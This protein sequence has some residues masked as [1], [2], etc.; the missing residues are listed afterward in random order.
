MGLVASF[1]AFGTKQA[2]SPSIY[3]KTLILVPVNLV[4]PYTFLLKGFVQVYS[5]QDISLVIAWGFMYNSLIDIFILTDEVVRSQQL[6]TALLAPGHI[7]SWLL[8]LHLSVYVAYL[9]AVA[10]SVL[11]TGP[12]LGLTFPHQLVPLVTIGPLVTVELLAWIIL[13][14]RLTN[15]RSFNLV[16]F[17]L[18]LLQVMSCV[19]YPLTALPWLLRPLSATLAPARLSILVRAI[20]PR[21]AA[22]WLAAT[23][24]LALVAFLLSRR[25]LNSYRMHGA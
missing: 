2:R 5:A 7:T 22:L 24:V 8:G 10:V 19:L 13:A 17:T 11:L 25:L 4:F 14:V 18:D 9:P 12:V 21:N 20:T 6:D 23:A 3:V 15:P 1:I 16:T